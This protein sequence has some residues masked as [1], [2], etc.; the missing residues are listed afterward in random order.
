MV[1]PLTPE[2][3]EA[4]MSNTTQPTETQGMLTF[5]LIWMGQLVSIIGSGLSSFVLG[6]WIYQRTGSTTLYALSA[7]FASLPIIL[8][9]PLAGA[10][11]D[12]WDRRRM[13]I[14]CN[15]IAASSTLVVVL[16]MAA[17]HLQVWHVYISITVL[18]IV[19]SFTGLAYSTTITLLVPKRH[20]GRSSGMNHATQAAA[21]ILPPLIAG[22]LIAIIQIPGVLV[23]DFATY[24]FAFSILLWVKIPRPAV[25]T[26]DKSTDRPLLREMAYGWRYIRTRPGLL[27]LMFYFAAINFVVGLARILFFPMVLSLTT[28]QVLGTVVSI[29]GL[30]F[31]LGSITM[32]VWGGPK[33]RVRGLLGFGLLF[34]LSAALTGLRPSIILIAIAAF[35][36]YACV[37]FINGCSQAIWLD[38]I[39]SDVQ[40]RVF[41]TRW[42]VALSTSPIAYLLAGPLADWC[43]EPLVK[44]NPG[45]HKIV[46]EGPGRG[47]GLIFIVAGILIIV[48]QFVGYLYPHLR[49]V[50]DELPDAIGPTVASE[51]IT[52]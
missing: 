8:M 40:G 24:L 22:A 9:L 51:G 33:E 18:S 32:G 52:P 16:L 38:K 36:M 1:G 25:I 11:V 20:Y 37:P 30:G 28:P 26:S 5:G 7:V 15:L 3:L 50:E 34:G 4:G 27:A 43:F 42:M 13:M 29:S 39:P 6:V 17:G 41:A 45:L 19:G 2:M 49:H 44:N 46:G 21:Q 47:T 12:R 31:L 14:Y 35:C 23:I 10:L 48:V